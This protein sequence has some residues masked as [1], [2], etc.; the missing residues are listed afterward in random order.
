MLSGLAS[1]L[2]TG[3]TSFLTASTDNPADFLEDSGSSMGLFGNLLKTLK[4]ALAEGY[5]LLLIVGAGVLGICLVVA[6]ILFGA[7][8]D[9]TAVRD[10]KKWIVRLLGAAIG[11]ACALTLV[12]LAFGIGQKFE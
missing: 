10:N 6:F 7:L 1:K 5:S 4:G 11:V 3:A 12:G 9:S 2:T 8:R